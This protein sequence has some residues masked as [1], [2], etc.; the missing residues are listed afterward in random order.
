[1]DGGKG[2]TLPATGR[3]RSSTFSNLSFLRDAAPAID[4]RVSATTT[5]AGHNS[6][7]LQAPDVSNGASLRRRVSASEKTPTRSFYHRTFHGPLDTAQYSSL[8][9]RER[10]AEIES[11]ALSDA[12]SI[13]HKSL[14]GYASDLSTSTGGLF[15]REGWAGDGVSERLT[16]SRSRPEAIEERSEPTTPR[17]SAFPS[18]VGES[19]LT[20]MLRSSPTSPLKKST[21][22][23]VQSKRDSTIQEPNEDDD[24][25]ALGH[26]PVASMPRIIDP[27]QAPLIKVHSSSKYG[28][29]PDGPEDFGPQRPDLASLGRWMASKPPAWAKTICNPRTWDKK[30]IYENGV[31]L[32]V[33]LLP[34][35]F[36]GLLLNILDALSY[37]M[38]L[39]P[40]GEPIFAAMGADGIAMFY[41]STII[42]QLVFSC[43]GSVF[44]GGIGAEMIEVVPF[45]HAMATQILNRVGDDDPRAV[46][47]TTI[48]AFSLSAILTGLV[49]FSMGACRLGSLIGF[50]PRHILIGCIGGVGWFLVVTGIEISARLSGNLEY[51]LKT[52]EKLFQ[53][54]TIPLWTVP[55]L[56]AI[57]LLVLKRFIRSNLLLCAYF[58]AIGAG[59]YIVK[60]ITNVS[61][62]SLREGGWVFYA[63]A[64]SQPWYHFYT[65]YDFSAVH[66]AA[67]AETVPAMFA[68]TFFGI[69]H[70]PI[71]VPALGISTGEDHLNVDRELVSHGISNVFS[72]FAGSVQNYL[73]YTNS[74]L[75]IASG[76][77]HR[78]AGIMLAVGT[79]GVLVI[80]P[81]IVGYIPIMIVGALIYMLGI[82]LLE[83]ALVDTWGKLHRLEYLTVVT[84]VVTMGA[85][86]FVA[87]I[88]VGIILACV[89]FVAQT[90]QKSAIT[91]TY[92]G[93][94]A[95][96]TV[97]R[98]PLH[99]RF[100]R[101]AGK[102]T[103]VIKL[104]G[105]LFFGTIVSVEKRI[106]GLVDAE[107][108]SE[109]PIRFLILDFLYVNGLDFSAAEAFTRLNRILKKK[110]VHMLVCGLDI[111]GEVATSLQN[112]GLFGLDDAVEIFQDLNSALEHC[113]NE[114]LKA[115]HDHK[116][117][118]PAGLSPSEGNLKPLNK[119]HAQTL[120]ADMAAN[121]PRG[122]YLHQLASNFLREEAEDTRSG[123][124]LHKRLSPAQQQQQPLP[125]L[126]QTF[127]GLSIKSAEFWL[128]VCPYFT[129][130]EF[131]ASSVLYR[132]ND[133]PGQFYLLE[134]GM[135][136]AEHAT[137]QGRSYFELIVA[138]RPC[139]ELSF[140]GET[141]RSATVR[142]ERDCVVWALGTKEWETLQVKEPT[143]ALELLKVCLKLTAE[144]TESITS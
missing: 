4:R 94:V 98:H 121:S 78:L 46:Y 110:G 23:P 95:L 9:V 24:E 92:T 138:G 55:L 72:G 124:I 117:T 53:L 8:G 62:S 50:F 7:L 56:L 5:T 31:H 144:R 40:L 79:F 139:G 27:E 76:G 120:A 81:G 44:K 109:R 108:F 133:Y 119:A 65:L 87:G 118:S 122:Y 34:A 60:F 39:F 3:R 73:V 64:S 36:L 80:G 37:G 19:A 106:R 112:V 51:N 25:T 125:L 96:S 18:F 135:L 21:S 140:F 69:L 2:K 143:V 26:R 67:L 48:L 77:N 6:D 90:S 47:A 68:L 45:F 12:E 137:P 88:I 14:S 100:L 41:V 63:P 134:S 22:A 123:K 107:A 97:R 116:E 42:S 126:L 86:D 58:V 10:T 16:R 38:I 61:M 99:A 54:D 84:I 111:T 33:S 113:E 74:L 85:W 91:A 136:R 132:E 71:N 15:T 35:V 89:N 49:F 83:E 30:F 1:M 29:I 82:E 141:S 28:A 13:S 115:I 93:Q 66:W 114:A 70:V 130:A 75:F 11:L 103:F 57:G 129:R 17:G 102:Q 131:A 105:F 20:A 128:P 104:A 43:G 127:Q 142:A 52:L 32:P 101:E 59:F